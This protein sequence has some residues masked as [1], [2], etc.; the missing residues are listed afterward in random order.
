MYSRIHAHISLNWWNRKIQ[1][2]WYKLFIWTNWNITNFLYIKRDLWITFFLRWIDIKYYKLNFLPYSNYLIWGHILLVVGK[3][4]LN[5]PYLLNLLRQPWMNNNKS[6]CL[7]RVLLNSLS[8]N[9]SE[10]ERHRGGALTKMGLG[11]L[12]LISGLTFEKI[13]TRRIGDD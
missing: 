11:K 6:S 9:S 3:I 5:Y 10:T 8:R 4:W 12:P 7:T 13:A 1:K 2:I